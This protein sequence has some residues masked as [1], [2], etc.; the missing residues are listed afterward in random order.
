MKAGVYKIE[1][2]ESGRI[3]IGSSENIQKRLSAHRWR[4][5]RK[6]H[7]NK[8]LQNAW[9]KHGTEA[10]IFAPL[11]YCSID[12]L[13]FYEQRAI[14]EYKSHTKPYGYNIRKFAESNR[15]LPAHRN[16]KEAI[17]R[18]WERPGFREKMREITCARHKDSVFKAKFMAASIKARKDNPEIEAKRKKAA[19]KATA[20]IWKGK[21]IPREYVEKMKATKKQRYPEGIKSRLTH[22]MTETPEHALWCK[23]FGRCYNPNDAKY[24][25]TGAQGIKVCDEWKDFE[26]F[27]KDMGLRPKGL[28]LGRKNIAKD[29]NKDNCQWSTAKMLSHSSR[30]VKLVELQGEMLPLSEAGRRLGIYF[31]SIAQR[32]RDC[33]ETYQQ[34]TDHFARKKGLL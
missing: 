24:P 32:A 9:L 11:L 15:G 17:K 6:V 16:T 31:T 12:D 14:D 19:A 27:Y 5:Q 26:K 10:F 2:K 30:T 3:Y 8:A 25:T 34:A 29:Y 33:N 23:M 21:K 13:L 22:G 18:V 28:F 4:L 1:H 20:L 7:P